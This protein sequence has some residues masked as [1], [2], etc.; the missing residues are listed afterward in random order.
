MVG[1]Q[2]VTEMIGLD[3]FLHREEEAA[4]HIWVD[5]SLK[6]PQSTDVPCRAQA[7][8]RSCNRDYDRRSQLFVHGTLHGELGQAWLD[9]RGS[10][11]ISKTTH[12]YD[13]KMQ[14]KRGALLGCKCCTSSRA[15]PLAERVDE[16]LDHPQPHTRTQ[17]LHSIHNLSRT[18]LCFPL[19]LRPL[20]DSLKSMKASVH[21][22]SSASY[23]LNPWYP[24]HFTSNSSRPSL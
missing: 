13:E 4:A 14:R 7:A 8:F 15:G 11:W 19:N 5:T 10:M 1:K 6:T 23:Q 24:A 20:A 2:N 16:H 22:K 12:L 9:E 18:E 17:C 21:F 3:S